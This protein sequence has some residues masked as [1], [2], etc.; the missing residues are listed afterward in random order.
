[1]K[2]KKCKICREEDCDNS[3]SYLDKRD[4]IIIYGAIISM[5]IL[6]CMG[7]TYLIG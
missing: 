6:L 4:I 1:M 2:K 5:A 7:L 3:C